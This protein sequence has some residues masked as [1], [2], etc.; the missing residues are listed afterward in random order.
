M[1][2]PDIAAGRRDA[3]GYAELNTDSKPPLN[4]GQAVIEASR[5][6]YCF[7]APCVEACPTGI[8]IPGFIGKISSGNIRGAALDIL[9]PN[10]FGGMCA[11]VCP[12]EVLCEQVCVRTAQEEKPVT[13]GLLQRH[14][15]DQFF[16]T[17]EQPFTRA[18][19]T[20]KKVA[21]VGAGPAGLSAAHR[22]SRFG[23][24]VT[25][26]EA[27]SKPGGL[28]EY[29]IA[30]YKVPNMFAQ[31]EA[32]FIL[33]LGGIE[34]QYG[35]ALGSEIT[36]GDLRNDFDAVFLGMGQ[37]GVRAL[38]DEGAELGGV[39]PAVK[40]IAE[41]RQ[42]GDLSKLP[43]GR[44]IVVIGGGNTAIDV[45]VQSHRLGAEDVTIVY[46]RGPEQMSAT[47]HEQEFAKSDG[48][49]I[50]HWAKPSRV[51]GEDGHVTGVE[52]E[53]TRANSNGGIEGT[54][55]TY[56]LPADTVFIAIGQMFEGTPLDGDS[57]DGDTLEI[58]SG[59]IQV[60]E[61]GATSLQGVYA[62]GDCVAGEDLTVQAVED[63][64]QAAIAID[65]YL[66]G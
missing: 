23:H 48:V 29:G 18:A 51:M 12:T 61:A 13:I 31:K 8:D 58:Q 2:H 65:Q 36:L 22:L 56:E 39:V 24:S 55:D 32:S 3:A 37:F 54:G 42:A 50:R 46:R 62:G 10:I 26:F 21:V 40:F 52:F 47:G 33:G 28:N 45:A 30:A 14:A 4:S 27:L 1:S 41:L 44:K 17:N 25:V 63:G 53:R 60:G 11:R 66:K 5:C 7:D 64:K 15:T 59:R 57:L 49:R 43:V 6:Y 9:E 34:V 20:G 38:E 19:D 35:K 16:A